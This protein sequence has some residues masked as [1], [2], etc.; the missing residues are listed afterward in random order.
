[1]RDEEERIQ[2]DNI[3]TGLSE[4]QFWYQPHPRGLNE[5]SGKRSSDRPLPMT[6][7][8]RQYRLRL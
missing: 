7:L 6:P 4:G 3:G 5:E 1:M 2:G 8:Y